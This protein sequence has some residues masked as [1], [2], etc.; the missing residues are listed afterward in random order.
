MSAQPPFRKSLAPAEIII[1]AGGLSSRMGRDKSR[2]RIGQRTL[3]G[4]VARSA[5]QTG[6]AVKVLRR[7]GVPRCGPIG[8]VW[9]GLT[10]TRAAWVVFLACDMP[11]V[12]PDF[13]EKVMRTALET[14]R[15]VF[16]SLDRRPGFPLALPRKVLPVILKQ[17]EQGQFALSTLARALKAKRLVP[18]PRESLCLLNINRPDDLKRARKLVR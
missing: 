4:H 2:I 16:T 6:L 10:R 14:S 12:S 13:L 11:L 1:L 8:G 3:A 15:P 9:T 7:D 17:I 5:R 18:S